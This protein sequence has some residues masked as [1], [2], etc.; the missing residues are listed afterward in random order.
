MAKVG[1]P[2]DFWNT[3]KS[4]S[5]AEIAQEANIPLKIALVGDPQTRTEV[6]T[7]LFAN[8][9]PAK[10]L[11]VEL[12]Q[13]E[14]APYADIREYDSFSEEAGFPQD[15]RFFNFVLD[16]G[17]D[18]TTA[19]EGILLYTLTDFQGLA[20][21]LERVLEDSPEWQMALAR[22]FPLL[23]KSV[24]ERLI[25]QTSVV[26]AE[27]ALITGITAA[28]PPT[29]ILLPVNALS[30]IVILTKNQ[31]MLALR[32]AAIYD[33]PVDYLK[34]SKEL[35]PILGNAF[36]WRAVA[37]EIVGMIPFGGFVVKAMIAYAG[38]ATLGRAAQYYY[39]TG[40]S[41]SREQL[42]ALYQKAYL[43]SK[44]TVRKIAAKVKRNKNRSSANSQQEP[45]SVPTQGVL[46]VELL[47]ISKE[48]PA[49]TATEKKKT[50]E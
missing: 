19:P 23:R 32:L 5:A 31:A 45:L 24:S 21:T 27:F 3:L 6:V 10:G 50:D 13:I 16:V 40:E 1:N 42:Q 49:S 33:L 30:D 43:S 36:G 35:V 8:P 41:L 25:T 44:E 47:P 7:A 14:T 28:F 12:R 34:R 17:A 9:T 37:R 48:A 20:P 2:K 11:S 15:P 29:A 22:N 26:N 39:E 4:V 38:T 46:E 18:R